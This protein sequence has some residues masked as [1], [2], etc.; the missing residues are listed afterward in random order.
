MPWVSANT[1]TVPKRFICEALRVMLPPPSRL[2]AASVAVAVILA[3]S[4]R[5]R[6]GVLM[7]MFPALPASV[8]WTE[9]MGKAL[10]VRASSKEVGALMVML[11]PA[12]VPFVSAKTCEPSFTLMMGALMLIS[13]ALPREVLRALISLLFWKVIFVGLVMLMLPAGAIPLLLL[14]IIVLSKVRLLTPVTVTFPDCPFAPGA[15]VMTPP[16]GSIILTDLLVLIS[17]LVSVRS[18]VPIM[19][20][21]PATPDE[22]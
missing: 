1:P 9:R 20:T 17:R 8:V 5:V 7:T 15:K 6:V 2:V 16:N 14:L 21:S 22:D 10:S 3:R 11:P 18:P 13:P 19:F 12:P 4:E